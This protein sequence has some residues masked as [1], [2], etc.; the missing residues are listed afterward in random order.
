[1]RFGDV[2]E[3]LAAAFLRRKGCVLLGRNVHVG[4][5]GEIDVIVRD[6]GVLVFVEVKTRS[7]DRF[8]APE[9]ALTSAKRLHFRRAIHGWLLARGLTGA[10]FRADVVAVDWSA[11]PPVI[12][13]H[14]GVEL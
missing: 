3:N 14:Q 4:R 13:H 7:S 10:R 6:G 9:D 5:M 8:G 11:E 2:G 12:R 1:M